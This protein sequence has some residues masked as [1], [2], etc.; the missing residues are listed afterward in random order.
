MDHRDVV[1]T[2]HSGAAVSLG[3]LRV[4]TAP[5]GGGL[6]IDLHFETPAMRCILGVAPV[7]LDALAASWN[8]RA[9]HYALPPGDRVWMPQEAPASSNAPL[10]S[11]LIETFPLPPPRVISPVATPLKKWRLT[12]SSP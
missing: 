12:G 4:S 7:R 1:V 10:D 11:P 9:Y 8:G 6:R 2:T 5:D 3:S